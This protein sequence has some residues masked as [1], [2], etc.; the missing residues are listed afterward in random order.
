VVLFNAKQQ[1]RLPAILNAGRFIRVIGE[2]GERTVTITKYSID[3]EEPVRRVV[4]C[5]LSHIIATCGDLGANYPDIVQLMIEAEQQHNLEGQFGI[6]RLPQAG[7]LLVRQDYVDDADSESADSSESEE[8][9]KKSA[10]TDDAGDKED[11]D[12]NKSARR[13]WFG[14]KKSSDS[15]AEE[16]DNTDG[17][18]PP[19][20]KAVGTP[21]MIPNLFDRLDEEEIR[22]QESDE[23]LQS[24]KFE[25]VTDGNEEDAEK[26]ISDA[27]A[28]K[29]S[30][31]PS[32]KK[33]AG[34]ESE[35]DSD[36]TSDASDSKTDS[37]EEQPA[38]PDDADSLKQAGT[39][40]DEADRSEETDESASDEDQKPSLGQ[41]MKNL[42]RRPSKDVAD[43]TDENSDDEGITDEEATDQETTSS[44]DNEAGEDE[45]GDT[46]ETTAEGS[47]TDNSTDES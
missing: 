37:G 9:D 27:A 42:F 44:E 39:S 38:E 16:P 17:P 21:A 2:A 7:R 8:S 22:R 15:D 25:D 36:S 3:K 13:R 30:D 28:G 29:E 46:E 34:D 12:D 43:E 11:N 40:D 10:S 26:E 18:E 23:K 32:D 41:R 6:D 1:L 45:S 47:D 5:S 31:A 35:E 20:G 19:A 4:D 24:L 14:G 33:N